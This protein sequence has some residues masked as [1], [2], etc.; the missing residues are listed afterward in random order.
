MIGDFEKSKIIQRRADE[1]LEENGYGDDHDIWT[2]ISGVGVYVRECSYD[3]RKANS[4]VFHVRHDIKKKDRRIF[5]EL[6]KIIFFCDE[7]GDEP[8]YFD[9]DV[10]TTAY[11]GGP[12]RWDLIRDRFVKKLHD[13]NIDW[14]EGN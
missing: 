10:C 13:W 8:C 1:V 9:Y 12:T 14:F 11:M 5:D 4:F 6:K 2:K 7:L 3:T